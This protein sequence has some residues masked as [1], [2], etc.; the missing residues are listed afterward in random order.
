M[1]QKQQ[2]FCERFVSI[3]ELKEKQSILL[4]KVLSS[5]LRNNLLNTDEK[6]ALNEYFEITDKLSTKNN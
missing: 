6:T 4:S 5:L 3:G 2:N 1:T